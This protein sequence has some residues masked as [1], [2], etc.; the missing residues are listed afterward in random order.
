MLY[1]VITIPVMKVSKKTEYGLRFLLAMAELP[2]GRYMGIYQISLRHK[3]PMKFLEAIAVTIK[4]SGLLEVK[5]GA[6]VITSYSI[7]Y[8]K[9]YDTSLSNSRPIFIILKGLCFIE[10]VLNSL[11]GLPVIKQISTACITRLS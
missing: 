11:Y 9:L 7:H 8:T 3:I 4:K 1:E 6:G 10:F 2:E 5:K